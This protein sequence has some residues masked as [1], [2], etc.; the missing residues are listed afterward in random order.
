MSEWKYDV[1]RRDSAHDFAVQL[2][3]FLWRAAT[4]CL[5][6]FG[7]VWLDMFFYVI[8]NT[9]TI[10]IIINIIHIIADNYYFYLPELNAEKLQAV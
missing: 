8:S 2:S 10:I 1:F 6:W 7:F 9:I 3:N 4:F 5:F